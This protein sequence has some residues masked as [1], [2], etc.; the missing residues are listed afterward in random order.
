M[1]FQKAVDKVKTIANSKQGRIAIIVGAVL[2]VSLFL[3][4]LGSNEPIRRQEEKREEYRSLIDEKTRNLYMR[5]IKV[6]QERTKKQVNLLQQEILKLKQR[7]EK[8]LAFDPEQ[9]PPPPA[10]EEAPANQELLNE[11]RALR[12]SIINLNRR[13]NQIEQKVEKTR[14]PITPEDV[15]Q[16]QPQPPPPMVQQPAVKTVKPG[17]QEETLLEG[18]YPA[19]E[20]KDIEKLFKTIGYRGNICLPQGSFGKVI[21]LSGLSAPTGPRASQDP[22]P[23]LFVI[24]NKFIKPN[25]RRTYKFRDCFAVGWG[26]GDLSSER[27]KI[28]VNSISC[29]LEEGKPIRFRVAGY[30]AGPDGKE[31]IKG[32][33]V[34]KRGQYL[35]KALMASF[36]E[37]LAAVARYGAT[38]VSVSPLGATQTI[39]PEKAFQYGFGVG[40][41]K[42]LQRLSDYYLQLA[43]EVLP[44]IEVGSGVEGTLILL[45]E[46]CEENHKSQQVA[47][48]ETKPIKNSI[49]Q[50]EV[51]KGFKPFYG[52]MVE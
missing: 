5:D 42:S 29:E 38:I 35:A 2:G 46:A 17:Q 7:L 33:L 43:D 36:V 26:A 48:K 52:G 6:E 16:F 19:E 22:V 15:P 14:A 13:I 44:V 34:E 18:F 47:V 40:L 31:G 24:P 30:V 25:L 37:G 1:D 21:A 8:E 39:P 20:D 3:G 45:K 32:I 9:T 27:I 49:K 41:E 23:I 50:E 51:E 10:Q 4:N 12:E 11:I 28:R